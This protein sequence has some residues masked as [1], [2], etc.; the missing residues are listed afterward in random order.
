MLALI[1]LLLGIIVLQLWS[2]HR[3]LSGRHE[4]LRHIGISARMIAR[5]MNAVPRRWD[6]GTEWAIDAAGDDTDIDE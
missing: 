5:H 6:D 2:L 3:V 1:A 4:A